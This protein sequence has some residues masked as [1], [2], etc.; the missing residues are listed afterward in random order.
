MMQGGCYSIKSQTTISIRLTG[1]N[2]SRHLNVNKL[3]ENTE[4]TSRNGKSRETGN[5]G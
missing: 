2:I 5:I 4:R 3:L 1:H